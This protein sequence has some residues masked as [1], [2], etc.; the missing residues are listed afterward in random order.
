MSGPM[1]KKK[2]CLLGSFGVGKTS[3]IERFVYNRFEERYLSTIGVRVSQKDMPQ[4]TAK[5]NMRMLIWDVEG[6][7]KGKLIY[8]NYFVGAAAAILVADITRPDTFSELPRILNQFLNVNPQAAL[9][10]AVNKIDLLDDTE[11]AKEL[12]GRL[13]QEL[14]RHY[15]FTSAKNGLN[16]NELFSFLYKKLSGVSV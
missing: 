9:I 8:K 2:I 13:P 11:Y 16:V 10:L 5:A 1:M 4:D 15:R 7:E 12:L 14:N 6:Y 3:L